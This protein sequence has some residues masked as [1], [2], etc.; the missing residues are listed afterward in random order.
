MSEVLSPII[1]QLGVGGIG[2]FIVG[3][4]L[5]KISKLIL[6]LV[7][8]FIIALIYLGVK[9]IISINY[10]ALFTAIGD[11][12][13]AASAASSWLVHVI[14]L[15]PFAGSFIAGFVIGFKLG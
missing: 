11:L 6:V 1:F 4:S 14:A 10:E 2:G 5:K 7:G 12:L 8:I 9:G 15:L 13:G 3:Y